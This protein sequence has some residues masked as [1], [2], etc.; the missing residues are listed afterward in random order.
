ML[1]FLIVSYGQ[2]IPTYAIKSNIVLLSCLSREIKFAPLIHAKYN[3]SLC[4]HA[5][6]VYLFHPKAKK[7]LHNMLG[8]AGKYLH[9]GRKRKKKKY[10]RNN[11]NYNVNSRNNLNNRSSSGS[12]ISS[13]TG[14]SR[15][16]RSSSSKLLLLL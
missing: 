9:R 13:N 15:S 11:S 14:S 8:L 3:M 12:S 1:Y 16:S 5:C 6:M 7:L 2:L 10:S 4:L